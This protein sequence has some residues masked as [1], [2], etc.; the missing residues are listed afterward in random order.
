[1]QIAGKKIVADGSD[2]WQINRFAIITSAAKCISV[3]S[4]EIWN[5][6]LYFLL[7]FFIY[8]LCSIIHL[9][10]FEAIATQST[11]HVFQGTAEISIWVVFFMD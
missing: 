6:I 1:M 3:S 8:S 5:V 9:F 11:L 4:L 10:F 7:S 2:R